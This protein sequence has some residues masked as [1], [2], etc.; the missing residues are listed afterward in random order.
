M[1]KSPIPLSCWLAVFLFAA[2]TLCPAQVLAPPLLRISVHDAHN[3][4]VA[5][6][7]CSLYQ[8]S[9]VNRGIA[10]ANSDEQ[11]NATFSNVSPGTY[12][13]I[14][15]KDGFETLTRSD[16]LVGDKSEIEIAVNL[17]VAAVEAKVTVA[18]REEASTSVAA[19]AST[20]AGS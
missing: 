4:P 2:K 11:G 5:D 20:P 3:S 9:A 15:D 8:P 12:T 14:V 7:K 19:G 1:S 6:A 17:A 18:M 13:L 16:V 10:K